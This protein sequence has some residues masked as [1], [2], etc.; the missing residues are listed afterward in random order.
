MGNN[1]DLSGFF[2]M[3]KCAVENHISFSRFVQYSEDFHTRK[4][5][6][7]TESQLKKFDEI[8][9]ELEIVNS[10]ALSSWEEEGSPVDWVKQWDDLYK[11]DAKELVERIII[12]L[13]A[14]G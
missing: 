6:L 14:K 1:M 8:W 13:E 2:S 4:T 7:F 5:K 12:L 3:A 9:F 10:L 11:N